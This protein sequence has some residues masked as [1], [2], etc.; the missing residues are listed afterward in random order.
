[1][2][3][4]SRHALLFILALALPL[5]MPLL[6][7]H[8]VPAGDNSTYLILGQA[9]ATGHGYKLISDPRSPG[10]GLYPPGYPLLLAAMLALSGTQGNLLAGILP[11]KLLSVMLYLGT[12]ILIYQLLEPRNRGLAIA[13]TLLTAVN[14]DILYYATE[15]DTEIPFL[16]LSLCC[17]WAFE[18]YLRKPSGGALA[19]TVIMLVLAFYVRS[20]AVVMVLAFALYLVV[21]RTSPVAGP[22]RLWHALFV[23]LAVAV[24]EAPWF[25]RGRALPSTGTAVGLG[26]GYF[27]L[28]FTSDPYGTAP[29]SLSDWLARL[30]QN[31]RSY[32]FEIWPTVLFPH[33]GRIRAALGT[34]GA[35]FAML[36][37]LLLFVG[38]VLEASRGHVS[39]WYT[40]TFFASCVAYMWAQS[41]LIVP[42]VPFAID[43]FL[44]AI[45]M[46]VELVASLLRQRLASL[47]KRIVAYAFAG[48]C[49]VLVL[50][51]LVADARAVQRNLRYGLGKPLST[52]YSGNQEWGNYLQAMNW[53][54][55]NSAPDSVV[56]CRK[57]DLMYVVTGHP[58]LEYPYT[59]D[60]P[61]LARSVSDNHVKYVI[62][63]AFS[64]TGTTN[65]YLRPA[66]QA[67]RGAEPEALSVVFET[68]TPSTLVWRVETIAN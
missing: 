52:Y 51:A 63:D 24:M 8:L 47:T 13:T 33:A 55:Q 17:L 46:V 49:V 67:W 35:A 1:M 64:W 9:L 62:E 56:M 57:A 44:T 45:C 11:C 21:R 19:R 4:A 3:L 37:T 39:E 28:Y 5:A 20:I 16:F 14:P 38:F 31:V 23:L 41:R 60:G 48:A 10:M 26:R 50:S 2:E 58:A 32:V 18:R 59:Q 36:L 65:D 68:G 29:A 53:V 15:L 66:L 6:N 12:L 43:Y 30:A 42:I 25:I 40:A 54:A 22:R 27:D 7:Q 61:T 34:V